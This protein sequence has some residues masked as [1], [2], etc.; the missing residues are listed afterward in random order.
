MNKPAAAITAAML[1]ASCVS[2][3]NSGSSS[4]N[5][6]NISGTWKIED[7]SFNGGYVFDEGGQASIF[8]Y[9]DNIYFSGNDLCF[10][11]EKIPAKFVEYDGSQMDVYY[12]NGTVLSLERC[13]SSDEESYNGEYVLEECKVREYMVQGLG[14]TDD[15]AELRVNIE[16]DKFR[17][18]VVDALDYTF[19]GSEIVL[20]G[21]NGISS[22]KGEAVL[23]GDKLTIKR[24]DGGERVLKKVK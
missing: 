3:G 7:N 8:I 9:P 5:E 15:D 6:Y 2:C 17:F 1:L 14:I 10:N 22:S 4:K 24:Q 12:L 19:N 20:D 18:T 11:D 13:G 23:S 16:D 21:K